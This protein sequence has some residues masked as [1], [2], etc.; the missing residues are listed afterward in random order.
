MKPPAGTWSEPSWLAAG[1]PRPPVKPGPAVYWANGYWPASGGGTKMKPPAGTWSEHSWLA[2]ATPPLVI[3][4]GAWYEAS[5]VPGGPPPWSVIAPV[6]LK[7]SQTVADITFSLGT[8]YSQDWIVMPPG[9]SC[10]CTF[11]TA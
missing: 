7:Q 8:A 5:S 9:W 1:G 3:V 4:L 11:P 2:A 6:I 10:R